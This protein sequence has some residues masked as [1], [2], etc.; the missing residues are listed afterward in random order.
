MEE[1]VGEAV[2]V[3]VPVSPTPPLPTALLP[4]ARGL[5]KPAVEAPKLLARDDEPGEE[6][7]AAAAA[8][9]DLL[10]LTFLGGGG[11]GGPP[12]EGEP[13]PAVPRRERR[14]STGLLEGDPSSSSLQR[15]LGGGGWGK[16]ANMS[17]EMCACRCTAHPPSL[18][19][20]VLPH[21]GAIPLAL[22]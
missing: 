21:I 18:F 14:A 2:E 4:R 3:A 10:L 7:Y 6:V 5:P 19:G 20:G 17:R 9:S 15:D 11:P 12:A 13:T 22:T 8:A 1:E 16:V